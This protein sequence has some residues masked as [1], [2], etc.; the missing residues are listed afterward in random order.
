MPFPENPPE[1]ST[2]ARPTDSPLQTPEIIPAHPGENR[3]TA[4]QI[5]QLGDTEYYLDETGA[6][7]V[8]GPSGWSGEKR[9]TRHVDAKGT[10]TLKEMAVGLQQ[11]GTGEI[12]VY[13]FKRPVRKSVRQTGSSI[14]IVDIY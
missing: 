6:I 12:V 7:C 4:G 10:P 13:T 5:I 1:N 14:Q 8:N 11:G 3:L 9:E 2:P